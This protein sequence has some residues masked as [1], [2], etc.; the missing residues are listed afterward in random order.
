MLA[1][2]KAQKKAATI[3]REIVIEA[4]QTSVRTTT[5][6]KTTA[7]GSVIGICI[8]VTSAWLLKADTTPRIRTTTGTMTG[9]EIVIATEVV[10]AIVIE[11][12]GSEDVIGICM[13][14]TA[15]RMNC[16]RLL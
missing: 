4:I 15:D 11:M 9:I 7:R 13:D 1:I 5:P 16:D 6:R 3:A 10:T 14:A 8:G 2:T 12:I